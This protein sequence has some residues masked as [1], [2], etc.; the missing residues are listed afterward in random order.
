[1]TDIFTVSEVSA[2]G[3]D[4]HH[5]QVIALEADNFGL[6]WAESGGWGIGGNYI[7]LRAF[8]AEGQPQ[9]SGVDNLSVD[10]PASRV[11]DT[12]GNLGVPQGDDGMGE[13][14]VQSGTAVWV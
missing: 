11:A 9:V 1:M 2:T 4:I 13:L 14:L 5:L 12:N 10:F 6:A 3:A 8:S 7:N